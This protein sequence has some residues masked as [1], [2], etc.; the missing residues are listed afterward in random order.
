MTLVILALLTIPIQMFG[1]ATTCTQGDSGSALASSVISGLLLFAMAA[2]LLS[3]GASNERAAISLIV[4]AILLIGTLAFTYAIWLGTIVYGTPC[5]ANFEF[6]ALE[7]PNRALVLLS[8]LM[9]PILNVALCLRLTGK[10]LF[11]QKPST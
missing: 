11:V 1:Y 2:L 7:A 4:T 3:K 5:G 6:Y 10:Q 9:L 8:Y